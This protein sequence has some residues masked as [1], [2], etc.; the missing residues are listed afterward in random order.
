MLAIKPA[1]LGWILPL[2]AMLLT[3]CAKNKPVETDPQSG[4]LTY[5]ALVAE[6]H[7]R[8]SAESI[9]G[10]TKMKLTYPGRSV[11]LRG[12][13]L[14]QGPTNLR[15]EVLS[16]LGQPVAYL[17]SA[18]F[19]LSLFSPY[20][21]SYLTSDD[22]EGVLKSVAGS[23]VSGDD[24]V[25]LLL[26]QVP[27][28]ELGAKGVIPTSDSPTI[29]VPCLEDGAVARTLR[30]DS[31]SRLLVGVIGEAERGGTFEVELGDHRFEEGAVLPYSVIFQAPAL[32]LVA[33]L[34]YEDM[35][36]N[37]PIDPALFVLSVPNGPEPKP[38]EELINPP[39]AP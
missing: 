28:C 22:P 36:L 21:G 8:P 39:V 12:V 31:E 32:E 19:N 10:T 9:Q 33:E 5:E 2:T 23:T 29:D 35:A 1:T 16:L 18:P 34:N 3:G 38:F 37:Q 24:L 27:A 30:F 17:V 26:G 20:S 15:A 11:K 7:A 6:A 13:L 25:G 14:A 4:P